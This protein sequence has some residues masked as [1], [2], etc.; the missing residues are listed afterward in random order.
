MRPKIAI[1]ILNQNPANY[2]NAV[3]RAG[4]EPVVIGRPLTGKSPFPLIHDALQDYRI[5]PEL[6]EDEMEFDGLIL[7]GGADLNPLCYGR[8]DWC[9]HGVCDQLDQLDFHCLRHFVERGKPVMGICRG[10]QV[11]NVYLGGDLYQ[12]I[13]R[14]LRPSHRGSIEAD[15]HHPGH[16][17]KGSFLYGIYGEDMLI[18]SNHHQAIRHIAESLKVV[19]RAPDGIVEAVENQDQSI[20]AVQWH[21]ERLFQKEGPWVDGGELFSWFVNRCRDQRRL[22]VDTRI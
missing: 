3:L 7:P 2:V 10:L 18:N 5:D 21:P 16:A 17:E 4:G 19:Q 1:C 15:Q 11:I 14:K 22:S 12:D 9:C 20:V 13:G 8:Q 6:P